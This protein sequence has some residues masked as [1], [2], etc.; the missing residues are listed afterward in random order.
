MPT[1]LDSIH[2]DG[3]VLRTYASGEADLVLRL[4]TKDEGKI[5][6]IA[7]QARKSKKR[8]GST[9]DVF[10]HGHFELLPGKS[11]LHVVRHFTP[12]PAFRQIR[13]DL[14]RI[15]C[16]SVVCESTDYLLVEAGGGEDEIYEKVLEMLTALNSST[17]VEES[18]RVA[19]YSLSGLLGCLGLLDLETLPNPSTKQLHGLLAIVEAQAG[20]ALASRAQLGELI[21]GYARKR[22]QNN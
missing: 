11:G 14:W 19:Y 21:T 18:L 17:T 8:F 3:I 6:A 10:D 5:S 1:P 20:R 12:L 2:C 16:A 7:K 22:A 9:L 15:T 4:L 13:E